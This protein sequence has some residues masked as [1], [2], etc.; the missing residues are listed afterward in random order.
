MINDSEESRL[1]AEQ[2]NRDTLLQNMPEVFKRMATLPLSVKP[3]E[4]TIITSARGGGKSIFDKIIRAKSLVIDGQAR[5]P[6]YVTF[7]EIC[8]A[9]TIIADGIILKQK[10][11]KEETDN[12]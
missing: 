8:V 1:A 4:L 3:G 12:A 5:S 10:F 11:P 2:F 9:E 7:T 6:M